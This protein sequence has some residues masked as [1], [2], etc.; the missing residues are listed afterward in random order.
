[1]D[2]G[3]GGDCEASEKR[4]ESWMGRGE[5]HGVW[6]QE[7]EEMQ[8][9]GE[10]SPERPAMAGAQETDGQEGLAQVGPAVNLAGTEV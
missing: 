2:L 10:G 1:M 4:K 3:S 8:T 9:G 7:R 6:S 5:K